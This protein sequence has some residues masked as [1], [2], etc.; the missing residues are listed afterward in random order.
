MGNCGS[1]LDCNSTG[2]VVHADA[3]IVGI[4]VLVAFFATAVVTVGAII[5]GYITDSL[6]EWYLNDL[7][8][9]IISAYQKSAFSKKLVP[10][11][12]RR[13]DSLK[14][15]IRR[16]IGLEPSS[17]YPDI[18][19]KAREEALTRFILALSDQQLATGLAVLI[20]GVANQ[21]RLSTY[22]FSI[23]LSLAWFSS[24]THLATLDALRDYFVGHGVVRNWRVAG[25]LTIL[26]LLGYSLFLTILA[27][28]GLSPELPIQCCLSINA[29]GNTNTGGSLSGVAVLPLLS[30]V[31]T[32]F[33]LFS[34][35]IVRIQTLFTRSENTTIAPDRLAFQLSRILNSRVRRLRLDRTEINRIIKESAAE[36]QALSLQNEGSTSYNNSFLSRIPGIAFSFSYGTSQVVL[37]RWLMK[38]EFVVDDSK[39]DFGQITP[40]LLLIIP[41]LA[42]AE[43]Y[44]GRNPDQ[45]YTICIC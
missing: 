10:W 44:Y 36:N 18:P 13:W 14:N 5:F 26:G 16:I 4:G 21:C 38:P 2:S 1:S 15:I 34:S 23:I 35:Y 41:V 9:A 20:A 12:W 39:M 33:I 32:L 30:T 28:I 42:A 19:R 27:L 40:L 29:S 22:E 7:D 43:I 37:Y 45:G 25:M 17:S 24:T 11:V 3:G 31:L 8:N 6:P